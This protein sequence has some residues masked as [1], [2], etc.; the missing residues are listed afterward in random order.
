MPEFF[1]GKNM[2]KSPEIYLSYR[3]FMIDTYRYVNRK[4]SVRPF[5]NKKNLDEK[6]MCKR[7][8]L[9][10]LKNRS[11]YCNIRQKDVLYLG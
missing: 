4:F 2:S 9:Y 7:K 11:E 3:N 5:R 8:L 10:I 1:N 6:L